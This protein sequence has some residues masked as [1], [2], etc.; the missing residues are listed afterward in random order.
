[1]EE[2]KEKKKSLIDPEDQSDIPVHEPRV[3]DK[4]IREIK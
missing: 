1:M 4:K 2:D 3:K